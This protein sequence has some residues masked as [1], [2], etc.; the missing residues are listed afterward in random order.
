MASRKKLKKTGIIITDSL[1]PILQKMFFDV[2]ARVG[3]ANAWTWRGDVFAKIAGH[4]RKV[5]PAN[6]FEFAAECDR[7]GLDGDFPRTSWTGPR[8]P[9]AE[10]TG[11][12][13]C[14]PR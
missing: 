13:H 11:R 10:D 8:A 6:F 2:R 14:C 5:T 1:C 7:L 4:T 12:R 9:D 3:K